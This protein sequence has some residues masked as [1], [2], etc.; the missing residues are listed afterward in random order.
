MYR[1]GTNRNSSKVV[2]QSIIRPNNKRFSAD[3]T[4]FCQRVYVF[5][6][7]MLVTCY[8]CWFYLY[9]E[10]SFTGLIVGTVLCPEMQ[11]YNITAS[12]TISIRVINLGLIKVNSFS[13]ALKPKSGQECPFL[14][15]LHQPQTHPFRR[16]PA[17][18]TSA[19][20]RGRFLHNTHKTNTREEHQRPLRNSNPLSQQSSGC[21]PTP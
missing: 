5:F 14:K 11:S 21:R 10:F 16:T 18:Q 7:N 1:A 20:R 13:M 9:V 6:L 19:H 4:I 8:R 12:I 3:R 2:A 15:F 17:N